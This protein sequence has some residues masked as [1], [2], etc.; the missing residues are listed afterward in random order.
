MSDPCVITGISNE[1]TNKC[2]GL[3]Q[4]RRAGFR[5]CLVTVDHGETGSFG[6]ALGVSWLATLSTDVAVGNSCGRFAPVAVE[7]LLRQNA[8]KLLITHFHFVPRNLS[9]N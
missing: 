1:A 9:S 7:L 4:H 5:L 8:I 2:V 6:L 3:I